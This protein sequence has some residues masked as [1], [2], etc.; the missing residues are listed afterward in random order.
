MLLTTTD[1]INNKELEYLGIVNGECVMKIS[2]VTDMVTGFADSVN[3]TSRKSKLF[4]GKDNALEKIK[5]EAVKLG[6]N[7]VVG[8]LI[9]YETA[10]KGEIMVVATGTAVKIL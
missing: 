1:N 10:K 2:I 7:A 6:A 9:N 3:K 4:E 8:V 5:S